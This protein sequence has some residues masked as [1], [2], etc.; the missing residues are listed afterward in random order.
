LM[1]FIMKKLSNGILDSA[2]LV[3]SSFDPQNKRVLTDAGKNN[4]SSIVPQKQCTPM[5]TLI[6]DPP[7]MADGF[8]R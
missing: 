2:V 3:C 1:E 6:L 5:A 7:H 4:C 8:L